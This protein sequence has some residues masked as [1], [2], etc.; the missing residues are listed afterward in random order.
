MLSGMVWWWWWWGVRE[1]TRQGLHLTFQHLHT[2]PVSIN[3]YNAY[4][5]NKTFKSHLKLRHKHTQA[6]ILN[7][8]KLL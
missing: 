1:I 6:H 5:W 8:F 7:K 4:E 3:Y 2:Y